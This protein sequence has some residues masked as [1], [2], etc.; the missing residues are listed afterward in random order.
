MT[1]LRH[2]P[3]E[4]TTKNKAKVAAGTVELVAG[5]FGKACKFS[6]VESTGPQ[7]FSAWV[8]PAENWD[9]YEG[10]SFWVK[11][12]GSKTFG[13][14]EFIDGDNFGLRY[15]YCF[16]IDS[17][18]WVKVNVA[19]SDLIPEFSGPLVDPNGGYAPGRFRNVWVGKW[20]IGASGRLAPSRLSGWLWRRRSNGRGEMPG[21]RLRVL[22]KLK[23]KQP[24]TIVTMGD[25][26]SD[27][28][29]WA[30]REKLWS[31]ILVKRLE[32]TYGSEVTLVNPAIGGTTLSQNVVL[33]PRWLQETPSP[34]LVVIW[35]G[36]NDWDYGVRRTVQTVCERAVDRLRGQLGPCRD[37]RDDLLP[38]FRRW[39]TTDPLCQAAYPSRRS[40]TGFA[41]A[42]GV[43]IRRV[44]ARSLE[45]AV[46]G[47]GQVPSRPGWSRPDCGHG[48]SEAIAVRGAC[49][50]QG[51][52][53]G[54]W[55]KICSGRWPKARRSLSGFEPGQ[56]MLVANCGGEIVKEHATKANT[57]CG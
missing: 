12:D 20:F 37:P 5:Q 57:P 3:S 25:S 16:P 27:K 56:D 13:G 17:T 38:R 45:A 52:P 50:S 31:E 28:R 30:N 39:E 44:R 11:G 55:M 34:D 24:V 53:E 29:H 8:N 9:Q 54:V 35:F 7:I 36:G 46:L 40:K 15:G 33:I 22:A 26:L 19:W 4:V 2:K 41:D 43:S 14:L 49:R 47:M 32:D 18:K 48:T 23:A 10:F 51:H 6:F 42:A 1:A 21:N